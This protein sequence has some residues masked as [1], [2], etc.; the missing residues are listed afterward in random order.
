MKPTFKAGYFVFIKINM[1]TP[2]KNQV[3]FLL[4][5]DYILPI[6]L[7]LILIKLTGL[8]AKEGPILEKGFFPINFNYFNYPGVSKLINFTESLQLD[9]FLLYI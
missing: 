7:N 1:K 3:S 9:R 4:V 6:P 2:E 8:C 5:P